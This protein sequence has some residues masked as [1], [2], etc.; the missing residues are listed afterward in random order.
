[1][2]HSFRPIECIARSRRPAPSGRQAL[3]WLL[4]MLC[5]LGFAFQG[6][7]PL[8]ESDEG[9]YTA[10]ALQ[11]LDSGDFLVPRLND[12]H[13]HYTKPPLT[14]WIIA[15]SVAA[16]G[17]N[18]W[19][20]RLPYALAFVLTGLLVY[21]LGRHFVPE[22]P[23]LPALLW[24][25]SLLAVL[26]A[27]VVS[28]DGFLVLFETLAVLAWLRSRE[29]ARPLR[30]QLLM[31]LAFGLAFLTKGP[32][33][34][35]PLLP[36]AV[37]TLA[38]EGRQG[39]R[40]LFPP[41]ALPVFA[42]TGL[43]WF[44][45]I[46][47][48]RPVLLGYFLGYELFDR[49]FTPVHD[50]NAQW[51][52]A[53]KVYLPVLFLAVF[54]WGLVD[55]GWLRTLRMAW[56]P[57]AWRRWLAEDRDRAFLLL[58]TLLPLCVFFVARSRLFLYVLPLA[59][60]I[61][62]LL[63][64]RFAPSIAPARE[65]FWRIA[66][67]VWVLL[68]LLVKAASTQI[69]SHKDARAEAERLLAGVRPPDRILFVGMPAHYGLRLYAGVP[70]EQVDRRPTPGAAGFDPREELCRDLRAHP[71]ALLVVSSTPG[72]PDP[73]RACP[74]IALAEHSPGIWQPVPAGAA[75]TGIALPAVGH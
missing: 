35:L 3:L 12:H 52:G 70:V 40:H 7:R 11:M 26:A 36:M 18:A 14:Y 9:R 39:L 25:S 65:P 24:G 44:V 68:V 28:T 13:E 31:G 15:A 32:P 51:Y 20:V 6:T 61:S 54:P 22:R 42:V 1:M 63:A 71:D 17:R 62:L 10:V 43:G 21:A 4:A 53:A 47:V 66:L 2:A 64:R 69:P 34:L 72:A 16:F 41:A 19:A 57:S 30:W 45:W 8:W 58:W 33:G 73:Q 56:R 67:P 49:V 48:Q 55:L 29:A 38:V 50:R 5:L 75:T 59:V 46:V 37:W 23:W 27:N 74:D 60:P